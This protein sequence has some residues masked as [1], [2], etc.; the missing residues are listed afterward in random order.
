METPAR[1][2]Y[3]RANMRMY[4]DVQRGYGALHEVFKANNYY[5]KGYSEFHQNKCRLLEGALKTIEAAFAQRPNAIASG[6]PY[7]RYDDLDVRRRIE[8]IK[9]EMTG[10]WAV[11][12]KYQHEL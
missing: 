12:I 11:H 9:K 4:L 2:A 10:L 1:K 6:D 5:D 7:L 8:Y 3:N